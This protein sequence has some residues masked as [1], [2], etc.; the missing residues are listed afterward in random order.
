ME[1]L[2]VVALTAAMITMHYGQTEASIVK[3][4]RLSAIIALQALPVAA[5]LFV[6]FLRLQN[7]LWTMPEERRSGKT[8]L[9]ESMSAGSIGELLES[10]ELVF[11]AQFH[12]PAPDKK[13][14]YW[15]G[16]V[17]GSFDGKTWRPPT[18]SVAR[19]P[20]VKVQHGP[21][22]A[23]RYTVTLEPQDNDWIFALDMITALPK[24]PD[25]IVKAT[26]EVQLIAP[27]TA[28]QRV[29]YEAESVLD[30]ALGVED[31]RLQ[32]QNWLELP[33]GF[34]PRTLAMAQEWASQERDHEKLIQRALDKFTREPFFYSL[35]PPVLGRNSVDEFLFDSK[36]GFCEHY[37]N[38]FVVLMRALDI[39]ARVVTGYQGGERNPIDGIFTVRAADA[40][41]WAEVWLTGR[42]WVR[43]DPTAAVA[44]DRVEQ[45]VR[46]ARAQRERS[47]KAPSGWQEHWRFQM[48]AWSNTW[49]QWVLN[50][51]QKKQKQ[52]LAKLG[53]RF[54]NWTELLGIMALFLVVALAG[55]AALTLRPRRSKDPL[56]R[57]YQRLLI[58]LARLGVN[59]QNRDTPLSLQKRALA[60]LPQQRDRDGLERIVRRYNRLRYD[61]SS[62]SRSEIRAL[63]QLIASW[64]ISHL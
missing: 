29:R 63:D 57:S 21:T 44:P 2:A 24:L 42:G 3:R 46:Q 41:A 36:R 6:L 34:N 8:G 33:P 28:G 60:L 40:H 14:L 43:V 7:P 17:L 18:Y 5:V 54:D 22:P 12:T 10:N 13:Q 38:A 20:G 1:L 52:L 32:Q 56:E 30:Y 49:N 11:R 19:A 62:P 16:P 47:E 4:L 23:V 9:S 27:G 61:V 55:I 59:R 25:S 45:S 39:P 50:Y 58:K 51:D 64:K 26:P 37:S 48:D 31:D 15:R 53:L 35:R